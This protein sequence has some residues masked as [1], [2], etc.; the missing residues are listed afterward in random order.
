MLIAEGGTEYGHKVT[1]ARSRDLYGPYDSN[2]ANPILTHIDENMQA[3]PIQGVGHAD[4]VEAH[5]GSWW[6]LFLGFRPQT[7]QHHLL[8][9]EVF[10]APIRWDTNAWPV[11]NGNGSVSL[12]M[13]VSH[14]LPAHHI[15]GKLKVIVTTL[16]KNISTLNGIFSAILIPITTHCRNAMVSFV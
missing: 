1:I 15:L 16:Q 5:D 2:P 3:S 4:F 13:N 8:G 9:R 11:I 10:L 14:L 7:G 12:E 6:T